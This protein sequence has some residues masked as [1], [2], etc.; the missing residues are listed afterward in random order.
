MEAE[1]DNGWIL[2]AHLCSER[3]DMIVWIVPKEGPVFSYREQWNPLL[4]VSGLVSDLE[5]LI[6]WLQ[7]PE[8]K[9][10]FGILSHLFEYKRLELGFV[11]K[12]RVLTVEAKG[13]GFPSGREAAGCPQGVPAGLAGT[14]CRRLSRLM[15]AGW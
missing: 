15:A 13:H 2:D 4:H 8:I 14:V 5:I 6:E 11:D 12:T 10:K 7:Q 9:I 1:G 3:K